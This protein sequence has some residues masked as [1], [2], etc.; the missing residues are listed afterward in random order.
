MMGAGSVGTG[1]GSLG[2]DI[3]VLS[4]EQ[5]LEGFVLAQCRH[6]CQEV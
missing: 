4:Q 6:Q 2:L 5:M 1:W 3:E